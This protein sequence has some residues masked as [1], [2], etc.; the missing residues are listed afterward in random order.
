MLHTNNYPMPVIPVTYIMDAKL[1]ILTFKSQT[2]LLFPHHS[3][4]I[5][6]YPLSMLLIVGF[7]ISQL[8]VF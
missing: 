2:L 5:P 7:A 1:P 3:L 6:Y 8:Y 4:T